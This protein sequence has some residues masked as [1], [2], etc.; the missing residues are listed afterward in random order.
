MVLEGDCRTVRLEKRT[1]SAS[2]SQVCAAAGTAAAKSA[3]MGRKSRFAI[4]AGVGS[5]ERPAEARGSGVARGGPARGA[6]TH[7]SHRISIG[8]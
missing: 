8:I 6:V 3:E 2:V 1:H 5:E 7:S 4:A